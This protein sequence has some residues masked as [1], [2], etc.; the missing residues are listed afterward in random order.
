[1]PSTGLRMIENNFSADTNK[2]NARGKD[3][4]LAALPDPAYPICN[5]D[6]RETCIIRIGTII[7]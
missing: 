2:M 1:M 4:F 5:N 3:N 6:E 7:S